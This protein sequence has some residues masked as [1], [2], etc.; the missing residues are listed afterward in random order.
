MQALRISIPEGVTFDAL[1]LT[2]SPAGIGFN[3]SPIEAICSAS[4]IDIELL[5]NSSESNV[6]GL[7]INWYLAHLDHGGS[8]DPIADDLIAETLAENQAGSDS[9]EPPRRLM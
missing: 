6:S 3:W 9:F 8:R 7:I 2:R 1:K 4:G 5:K